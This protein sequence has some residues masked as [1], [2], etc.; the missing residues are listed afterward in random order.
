MQRSARG[1]EGKW[2]WK[3]ASYSSTSGHS[4]K[5]SYELV[6]TSV[7]TWFRKSASSKRFKRISVARPERFSPPSAISP[8]CVCV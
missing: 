8:C 5:I 3:T 2:P 4:S 7:I 1:R 6:F